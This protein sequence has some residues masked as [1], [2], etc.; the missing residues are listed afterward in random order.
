M[1]R[2]QLLQRGINDL[3]EEVM[4]TAASLT[5]RPPLVALGN[6]R[7]R[8]RRVFDLAEQ[9]SESRTD[10]WVGT[11]SAMLQR[12]RRSRALVG[13]RIVAAVRYVDVDYR[14]WDLGYRDSGA[15]R[16]ITDPAEWAEPTWDAGWFHRVDYAIE[17]DT[18]DGQT[19]SIGWD[20]PWLGESVYLIA[21]PSGA[22]GA[23]WDVTGHEPWSGHLADP[24]TDVEPRYHPWSPEGGFWCTRIS[25][26]FGQQ[27][28]D[29]LLG[30]EDAR[31]SQSVLGPSANNL[32]VLFGDIELPDWERTDDLV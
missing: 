19:W 8:W 20:A 13:R 16:L 5:R 22:V 18:A 14:G 12:R 29:V 11:E 25:L 3:S 27:Y 24:L 1:L 23:V 7:R 32:A 17:F 2:D 6:D 4:A 30:D 9:E 15:R 31:D 26:L 21:E 10:G 28:I